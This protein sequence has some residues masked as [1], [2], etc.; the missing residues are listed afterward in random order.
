MNRSWKSFIIIVSVMLCVIIG[1]TAWNV[2][3]DKITGSIEP[4]VSQAD[5]TN[6][7][8]GAVNGNDIN[9]T[10]QSGTETVTN[11]NGQAVTTA[12]G[13]GSAVVINSNGARQTQA[14]QA[15]APAIPLSSL[16]IFSLTTRT[17]SLPTTTTA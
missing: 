2:A 10:T 4:G 8:D 13:N 9:G 11:A 1:C 5:G 17:R 16:R 7:T 12:S 15:Q 3:L 14:A 6:N